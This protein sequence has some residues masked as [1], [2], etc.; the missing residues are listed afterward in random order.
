MTPL[1]DVLSSTGSA[2]ISRWIGLS[3]QGFGA[4]RT[5]LAPTLSPSAARLTRALRTTAHRVAAFG[6]LLP[7][8]L[9]TFV[10]ASPAPAQCPPAAW[11]QGIGTPGT[12]FPANNAMAVLPG[13]DVIVG[14]AFTTAGGAPASRIARYNPTTGVWSTL[15]AGTDGRVQA[16]AVLPG[17]DVIVGGVFTT[18]GGMLASN[19]A[20]VN[21]T[22]G[23]WTTMGTGVNGDVNALA[24]LPGGDVI[25]GG[26]FATAGG[27]V[28]NHI[29]RYNPNTR[30]WSVL[31]AGTNNY[32]FALAV[33]P[34]G[35]VIASGYFT[36]AGG[37]S[38]GRIARYNPASG[39]WSALGGA[40]LGGGLNSVP[41]ALTVL[42]NG[43]V[44]AG[45]FFTSADNSVP[46]SRI[47]RYNPTTNVWSALGAGVNAQ[48]FALTALPGGDVIAGG[49][50][51]LSGGMPA[52]NIARYNPTTGVWSAPASGT[53]NSVRS[54]V[55]LPGGD[56]IVGGDF[57][58]AG[59]ATAGGIARYFPGTAAP[60]MLS[61]PLP[62]VTAASNNA[63]FYCGAVA[64]FGSIGVPTYQ[65]RKGGVALSTI[66]NPSAATPVLSLTNVQ[67]ADL[68]SYDCLV[69]NSCGGTGTLSNPAT[70]TFIDLGPTRCGPADIANDDGSPLPPFGIFDTNNGVTEGDYNLFFAIFFDGCAF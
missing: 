24:V 51:T 52:S 13:G 9:M 34:G 56:L 33:L 67:P 29:A 54:L 23:N 53:D 11:V 21:P 60:S 64:G 35:D 42:P 4:S 37:V 30:E 38:A 58:T 47:A 3:G 50:F 59:G 62:V 45:G 12:S 43:D 36:S 68:G 1:H 10:A 57:T 18:A 66:T 19:I 49:L 44:I 5:L 17:G 22:T 55:V 2:L 70:L 14:G 32:V 31:G 40:A 69:T 39:D 25:V 8:L 27:M 41:L 65:W 48:V 20:R 26:V 63:V 28:A 15:G 61:Q 16:L 6:V 46:A 7:A